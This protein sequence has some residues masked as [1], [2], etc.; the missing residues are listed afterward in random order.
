MTDTLPPEVAGILHDM[1]AEFRNRRESE[2]DVDE[3]EGAFCRLAEENARLREQFEHEKNERFKVIHAAH[4]EV[5]NRQRV[6]AEL[7]AL[8]A[9]IA[10]APAEEVSVDDHDCAYI[11]CDLDAGERVALVKLEDGE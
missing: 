4:R 8:K 5:A 2:C 9:R 7:A 11:L 1:R 3:I 10:E 6:E